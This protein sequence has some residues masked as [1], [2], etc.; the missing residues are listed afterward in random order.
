MTIFGFPPI[1]FTLIGILFYLYNIPI[2]RPRLP[3]WLYPL[4]IIFASTTIT[5]LATTHSLEFIDRVTNMPSNSTHDEIVNTFSDVCRNSGT[6]EYNTCNLWWK[7]FIFFI[8]LWEIIK[9]FTH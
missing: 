2:P 6:Y 4:Y 7:A 1:E 8:T 3:E 5:S 9:C